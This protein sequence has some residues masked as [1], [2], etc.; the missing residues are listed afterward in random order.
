MTPRILD[1]YCSEGGAAHGYHRAGWEV[2]GVD[3]APQTRYPFQ[4]FQADVL[5]LPDWF[6][7]GFD[8]IHASPPCQSVR[9]STATRPARRPDPATRA[10]LQRTGKPYV[11]ENVRMARRAPCRSGLLFG[12]M[13]GCHMPHRPGNGSTFS[14]APV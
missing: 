2:V 4:F 1:L 5:A 11:I 3:R 13:F 7:A 14:R 10:M 6:L 8:A 9:S 12:Q